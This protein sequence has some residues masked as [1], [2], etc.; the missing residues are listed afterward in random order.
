[1]NDPSI[2]GQQDNMISVN[3]CIELDIYG[4]VCAEKRGRTDV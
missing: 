3:S 1:M 4:Q 2:I